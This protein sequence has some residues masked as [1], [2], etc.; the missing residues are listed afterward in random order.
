MLSKS[1]MQ[2]MVEEFLKK[3]LPPQYTYHCYGHTAYVTDTAIQIARQENCSEQEIDLITAAALWHD[4]GFVHTCSDHEEQSCR[5]AREYLPEL[6]LSQHEIELV[7][8]MIMATK[9]PQ[10]PKTKLEE[11]VADADLEYLG[12]VH[13]A[14]QAE[15]LFREWK[16]LDPA[17]KSYLYGLMKKF[18]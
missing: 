10:N 5:F 16:F 6:G 3:H 7:C 18:K 8:G 14:K 2:L 9:L 11:I 15:L 12:T 1:S 13:A 17:K 4:T